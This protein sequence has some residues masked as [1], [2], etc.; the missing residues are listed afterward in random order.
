MEEVGVG[1]GMK[2]E[3]PW[4]VITVSMMVLV[5][6][7][8]FRECIV[9]AFLIVAVRCALSVFVTVRPGLGSMASVFET[10]FVDGSISEIQAAHLNG[11]DWLALETCPAGH[12]HIVSCAETVVRLN[13]RVTTMSEIPK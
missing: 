2:L 8:V 9:S 11:E 13:S 6:L 1:R 3:V 7:M 10:T 5:S 4:D 12:S